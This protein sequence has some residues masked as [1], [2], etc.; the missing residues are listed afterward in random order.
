[1]KGDEGGVGKILGSLPSATDLS[2]AAVLV[3]NFH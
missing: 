2:R 1:M 3:Q